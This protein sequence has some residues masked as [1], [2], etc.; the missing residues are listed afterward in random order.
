MVGPCGALW[1][2]GGTIWLNRGARRLKYAPL[3]ASVVPVA[4]VSSVASVVLV[5]SAAFEASAALVAS[6]AF[7]FPV[8]PSPPQD[9][10]GFCARCPAGK[11]VRPYVYGVKGDWRGVCFHK[12]PL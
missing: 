6:A 9:G 5:T 10:R 7:R 8:R 3:V 4:S 11:H 1:K 2:S 12:T